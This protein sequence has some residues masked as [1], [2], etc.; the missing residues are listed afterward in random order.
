MKIFYKK[1]F[2]VVLEKL[3]ELREEYSKYKKKSNNKLFELMETND[4]L[5]TK[6]T[7][8]NKKHN[9][10]LETNKHLLDQINELKKELKK[11][12]GQKGMLTRKNNELKKELKE[13][14]FKLEESMTDKYLV[15]KLPSDKTPNT[16]KTKNIRNMKPAVNKFLKYKNE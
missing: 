16:N 10:S 11:V 14:L 2:Q 7:I 5:N 3:K 9:L 15:R 12:Y 4:K 6:Y 8:V 1:D 13:T